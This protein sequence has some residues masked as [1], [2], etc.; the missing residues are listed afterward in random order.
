MSNAICKRGSRFPRPLVTMVSR[1]PHCMT[2]SVVECSMDRTLV[3]N[4]TLIAKPYLNSQEEKEL[5]TYLKRC[6]RVGYGRTR[7]DVLLSFQT[8][9][10]E[11]GVLRSSRV[12]QVWW[13][14]FLQR[15]KDLSLRQGDTTAHVRKDAMNRETISHY[16]SLLHDTL[17]TNGLLDKPAQIYNVDETGVPFDPRPPK[18]V[19]PKGRQMKVRYRCAGAQRPNHHC[20][21]RQCCRAYNTPNGHF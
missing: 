11:K 19:S 15:Q 1:K 2:G 5:A 4:L 12:S 20:C 10:S 13:R 6:A 8:T 3:P 17:S 7:Q 9:A 14:R 16:F 18:V 21:L